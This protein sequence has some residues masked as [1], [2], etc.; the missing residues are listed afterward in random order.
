MEFGAGR[1]TVFFVE[2]DALNRPYKVKKLSL[3]SMET[4]TVFVDSD[5]THYVDIGITKDG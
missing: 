1:D 4:S 3:S 2:T 5:P